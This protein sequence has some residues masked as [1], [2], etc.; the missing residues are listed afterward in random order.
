MKGFADIQTS[1]RPG[2]RYVLVACFFAAIV[3]LVGCGTSAKPSV[4]V[5]SAQVVQIPTEQKPLPLPI[6][7]DEPPEVPASPL[8]P[9]GHGPLVGQRAPSLH[10]EY[11]RGNGPR[12]LDE[13]RGKVVLIDFW[14]TFCAPCRKSFPQYEALANQFGGE[15][16]V[17]AVS[18]DEPADTDRSQLEEFVKN[19]GVKFPVLWDVQ[20]ETAK[21][22]QVPKMPSS[23]IVDRRGIVRYVHL[24]YVDGEPEEMARQIRVLLAK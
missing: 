8:L 7:S 17:L 13:A 3:V 2:L 10:A 11:V 19:T 23:Y 22:Y 9:P 20:L 12:D 16:V 15:L 24:G 21:A 14:A 6:A 18:V 4:Q 5:A 1:P